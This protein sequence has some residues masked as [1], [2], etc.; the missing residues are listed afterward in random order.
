MSSSNGC[1]QRVPG[2]GDDGVEED[3]EEEEEEDEAV[4]ARVDL[5]VGWWTESSAPMKVDDERVMKPSAALVHLNNC[6]LL[7][8]RCSKEK[9]PVSTKVALVLSA[10]VVDGE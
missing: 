6:A 10:D 8:T 9:N 5:S 3:D 1:D 4:D 7:S 2:V